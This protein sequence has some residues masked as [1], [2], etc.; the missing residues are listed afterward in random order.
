MFDSGQTFSYVQTDAK[1]PNMVGPTMLGVVAS[2]CTALIP[3]I[4]QPK[5]I[6]G[7]TP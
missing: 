6:I 5:L 4:Y 7:I 2:I 3:N 1:T